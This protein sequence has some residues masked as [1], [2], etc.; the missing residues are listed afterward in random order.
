MSLQAVHLPQPLLIVPPLLPPLVL[1]TETGF[2]GA[3]RLGPGEFDRCRPCP[4][5]GERPP[6]PSRPPGG[7]ARA[8]RHVRLD[9]NEDAGLG[10]R[11]WRGALPNAGC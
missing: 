3:R 10:R 4:D 6:R 8:E 11:R 2:F 7:G 1:R 9:V 5:P